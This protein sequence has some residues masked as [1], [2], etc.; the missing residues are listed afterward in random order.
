M[1][2]AVISPYY[3]EDLETLR[4][5]HTSV[6]EQTYPCTHFF[7]A[8]GHPQPELSSWDVQHIILPVSHRDFGNTPRG[9]GGI[10]ALNQGFDAIAYLDADNWYAPDHVESLVA[11]CLENGCKVAFSSRHIVLSTGELF[12]RFDPDEAAGKHVDTSCFFITAGAAFLVPI[13]AMMDP[14][15]S[16]ICDRIMLNAV[17]IHGVSHAWTGRKTLYYVSHWREHFEAMGKPPPPDPHT[18][19]GAVYDA[20]ENFN[21]L[22]FYPLPQ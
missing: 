19:A 11:C 10:S 5:C 3:R 15:V 6:L 7:V 21:R 17:L 12:D 4:K 16:P 14:K 8:D 9:I 18:S 22:G 1:K 2:V 13:W 20:E